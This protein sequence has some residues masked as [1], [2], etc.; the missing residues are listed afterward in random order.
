MRKVI[1]HYH[2]F[3]NAGTSLDAAFKENFSED[4]GEWVTKEFPAQ[5]ATNREKVREWIL[6]TQSAKCFSSHTAIF[7]VPTFEE[8]EVIPVI[9]Y[10]HPIDRIASAYS[11]EKKQGGTGFGSVLARN[12][13]LAGYIETRLSLQYDR[14]CRDFHSS[15]LSTMYSQE[16]GDELT[17]SLKAI[18]E[19]PFIGLVEEYDCSLK[20]LNEYINENTSFEIELEVKKVNVSNREILP[21]EEK[22]EK[23]KQKVGEQLYE[24]LL[25][26]N[27]IDLKLYDLIRD[28]YHAK[29]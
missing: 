28:R 21:L 26:A 23:I 25:K 19:L 6:D 9:F 24:E 29:P 14:Q 18:N 10:R 16:F 15:R 3:K 7:P 5:P 17:R 11:F 13:S 20:Q 1:L 12:T 8:I 27:E 2:L 4:K 22:L